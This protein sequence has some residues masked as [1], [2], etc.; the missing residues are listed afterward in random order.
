MSREFGAR[1]YWA[2]LLLNACSS[3]DSICLSLVSIN[4]ILVKAL[5]QYMQFKSV[6]N[7]WSLMPDEKSLMP[8]ANFMTVD[9][10]GSHRAM[11]AYLEFKTVGAESLC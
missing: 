5:R 2:R 7:K 8:N 4:T 9:K 10:F 3:I 11:L 1:R 6:P